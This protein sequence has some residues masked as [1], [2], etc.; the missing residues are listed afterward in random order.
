MAR[1]LNRAIWLAL[2]LSA[3]A[4]LAACS[5]ASMIDQMPTSVGGEP[6][7]TP[8]RSTTAYE[9]PAVHDMPPPRATQA[10]DEE[11]EFKA[12]KDLAAARDRQ[13]ARTGTA[14]KD[15]NLTKKKPAAAHDRPADAQDGAATKP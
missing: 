11:T 1:I 9:Y 3:A 6:A 7:G 13:E 14:Q 15:V 12:E 10:M 2:G 8:A 4:V 5:S